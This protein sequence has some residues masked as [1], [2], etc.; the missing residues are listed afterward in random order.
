MKPTHSW[1]AV[2]CGAL[3][4]AMSS[5][6]ATLRAADHP[7]TDGSPDQVGMSP[8]KLAQVDKALAQWV[9][10][11]RLPGGIV[12]A[13]RG[14]KIVL[15]KAHGYADVEAQRPMTVDT[16]MMVASM[17]KPIT[18]TAVMMLAERGKLSI[19]DPVGKY[20][21]AFKDQKIKT[22]GAGNMTVRQLLCHT[23]GMAN[24]D[25]QANQPV[26]PSGGKTVLTDFVDALAK[27]PLLTKPGTKF[28]YSSNGYCVLGRIVE[29]VS[30]K[31]C[32]AFLVDE[33]LRPLGMSHSTFR[34]D[35]DLRARL[36]V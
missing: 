36:A 11:K 21:P 29:V 15:A 23:S 20:L 6:T 17:T 35:G 19:D 26:D 2:V 7:L 25:K 4:V 14:G 30:G 33:I 24:Q 12:L 9:Q 13:A 10:D 27:Q 34:I 32:E 31:T 8:E 28:L 3:L 18:A 22:G 16:P 1:F 5:P